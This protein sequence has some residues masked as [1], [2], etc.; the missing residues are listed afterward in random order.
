MAGTSFSS[1]LGVGPKGTGTI[2]TRVVKGT[3]S[4]TVAATAAAGEEDVSLTIS[5]AAAG[6]SVFLTPAN[7]AMETGVSIAA[8]WV[9]AANT[10]KVRISNLSGSGLT[11]ST[12]DWTYVLIKS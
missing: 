7:A 4:V 12:S 3:V 10:V 9:S 1:G 2:L 8:V 6:D 5:G 11:G